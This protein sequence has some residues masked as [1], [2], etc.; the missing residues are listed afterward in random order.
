MRIG[1]R[2]IPPCSCTSSCWYVTLNSLHLLSISTPTAGG[3]ESTYIPQSTT[4]SSSASSTS[5]STSSSSKSSSSN[6]GA[7]AGGVV[8]GVVGL[9][10]LAALFF[11]WTRRRRAQLAPSTLIDPTI[12]TMSFNHTAPLVGSRSPKLYVR[13]LLSPPTILILHMHRTLPI[14]AHS[15]LRQRLLAL[16]PCNSI[17]LLR[18]PSTRIQIR[19]KELCIPIPIRG[20]IILEYP[21]FELAWA[22]WIA[23]QFQGRTLGLVVCM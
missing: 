22:R 10:L 2:P 4:S 20:T 5:T 12:S 7:I 23:M 16:T 14:P 9:A 8:G 13:P 18:S 15:L 1:K 11:W 19:Y 6:A 3:S 21:S 17:H